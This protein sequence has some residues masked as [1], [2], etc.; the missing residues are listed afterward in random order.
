[1]ETA[2][3]SK[4]P[5]SLGVPLMTPVGIQVHFLR[6]RISFHR[7]IS[8]VFFFKF[9]PE[10]SAFEEDGSEGLTFGD[11]AAGE[12]LL[13]LAVLRLPPKVLTYACQPGG[14][15]GG[16]ADQAEDMG[17]IRYAILGHFDGNF[18]K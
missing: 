18:F 5:P 16:A 4:V 14:P 13:L 7:G 11:S 10:E 6:R 2:A 1:M 8:G 3:I 15:S 9:V 12:A 17:S